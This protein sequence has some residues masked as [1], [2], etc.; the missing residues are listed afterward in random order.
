MDMMKE[1]CP[2]CGTFGKL[3]NK[4][5]EAFICPSCFSVFSEFGFITQP[6]TEDMEEITSYWN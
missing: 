4:S 6:E 3:W 1:Q 5:P 2:H